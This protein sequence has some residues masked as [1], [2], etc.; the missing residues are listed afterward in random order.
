[1]KERLPIESHR[2]WQDG[3]LVI[4]ENRGDLTLAQVQQA[5]A[6]YDEVLQTEGFLLLLLE[7]T[8]SA[9]VGPEARRHLAQWSRQHVGRICIATVGGNIFFRTSF[10]LV[11][12][13]VRMLAGYPIRTKACP[14]RD[15]AVAWLNQQ[16]HTYVGK[17]P[18][19]EEPPI[20]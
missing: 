11:M 19:K 15:I 17:Q 1:M 14:D 18:A 16:R 9:N 3:S 4:F 7:L 12:G 6:V 8:N 10:T 5:T 2:L 13:A 20:S